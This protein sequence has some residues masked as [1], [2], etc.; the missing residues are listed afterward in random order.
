MLFNKKTLAILCMLV[1]FV[2]FYTHLLTRAQWEQERVKSRI[3]KLSHTKIA[4]NR[5]KIAEFIF[6]IAASHCSLRNL[7]LRF[8]AKFAKISSALIYSRKI[9]SLKAV[10]CFNILE[11]S[12]QIQKLTKN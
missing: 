6:T 4:E 2:S 5:E 1:N 7:L 9:N 12:T 11:I 8:W 3:I 10:G